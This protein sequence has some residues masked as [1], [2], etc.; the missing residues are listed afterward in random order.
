MTGGSSGGFWLVNYSAGK[1]GAVN[2]INGLNSHTEPSE[3]NSMYSPYFGQDFLDLRTL[4]IK[5]GA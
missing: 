1:T 3:P 4:A 5:A 2:Y